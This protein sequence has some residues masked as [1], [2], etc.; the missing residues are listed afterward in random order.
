LILCNGDPYQ[1]EGLCEKNN[2]FI[3]GTQILL[4]SGLT[5]S[6]E[7]IKV[8]DIVSSLNLETGKLEKKRVTQTFQSVTDE[9]RELHIGDNLYIVTPDHPFL[10]THGWVEAADLGIGT[11]IVTRAGPKNGT[12]TIS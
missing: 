11:E 12:K 5:K 7:Q 9:L 2:C 3:A 6:I 1:R 10:T 8:G 4:G